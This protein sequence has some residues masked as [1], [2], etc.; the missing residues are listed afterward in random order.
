MIVDQH[1]P[2]VEKYYGPGKMTSVLQRLLQEADRVTQSLV[3]GWIEE[4]SVKR[5][6]SKS[7]ITADSASIDVFTVAVRNIRPY[8]CTNTSNGVTG[9][10]C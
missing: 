3:E 8:H 5:R 7:L 1:Q 9:Q 6:V 2:V 4:R 10:C